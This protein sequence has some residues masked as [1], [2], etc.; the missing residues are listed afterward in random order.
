MQ[1]GIAAQVLWSSTVTCVKISILLLYC[2][3]FTLTWFIWSARLIGLICIGYTMGTILAAFLV[4][5]PLPF[6]WDATIKGGHCGNEFLSYIITGSINIATDIMVLLLP[7]PCLAQLELG[8]CKRLILI[9]TFACGIFTC[10]VGAL[11]LRAIVLVDFDDYTYSIADAMTYSALEPALAIVLACVPT[12]RPLLPYRNAQ[13]SG[14]VRGSRGTS[15]KWRL[16][17][18][19]VTYGGSRRPTRLVDHRNG[20][21]Q[22]VRFEQSAD[23]GSEYELT[24]VTTAT[25]SREVV[26]ETSAKMRDE[27]DIEMG[28]R[29]GPDGQAESERL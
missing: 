1:M 9:A 13:S 10:V 24:A 17:P 18:S 28:V 29:T 26:N 19:L 8:L 4:C 14:P 25:A 16:H 5:S 12:L 21:K 15:L 6:Y 3:I 7:I 22:R 11:R 2:R 27:K 23:T 20:Q